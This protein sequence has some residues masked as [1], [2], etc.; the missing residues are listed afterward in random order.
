ME[1]ERDDPDVEYDATSPPPS[2][3]MSPAS[4]PVRAPVRHQRSRSANMH[5]LPSSFSAL[6]PESLPI[7]T[8]TRP[9][10]PN[11]P[12][13]DDRP[14]SEIVR[15][16]L[17]FAESKGRSVDEYVTTVDA[18]EDDEKTPTDPRE[19][20]ILRLVAASTPSHRSAWKKDSKAWQVFVARHGRG[21]KTVH[22]SIAEEE[23]DSAA[24]SNNGRSGYYDESEDDTSGLE[25]D[26]SKSL[27]PP[28]RPWG[29][30]LVSWCFVLTRIFNSDNRFSSQ[31]AQSLPIAIDSGRF[32]LASYQPKTSLSDRPGILVPPLRATSKVSS[33]ALKRASYAER[34]RMRSI[35]PGALDFTADDDDEEDDEMEDEAEREAVGGKGR[36]RALKILE[37]RSELP[38]EGELILFQL[39]FS[40]F[41]S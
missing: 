26:L 12:T 30:L 16:S 38:A 17:L 29:V 20:E 31:I 37:A 39:C 40:N 33:E 11:G 3:P 27:R 35:D 1:N 19:A 18:A 6:R 28:G 36:Q 14:R 13:V 25:D 9:P 22:N 15:E 4:E 8:S 41:W 24:E 5:G 34:D 7:P 23:E 10:I 21:A 2:L 32:G